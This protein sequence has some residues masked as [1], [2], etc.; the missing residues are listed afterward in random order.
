MNG[1][2]YYFFAQVTPGDFLPVHVH[3]PTLFRTSV[4]AS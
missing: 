4:P 1:Y 3:Q 2:L